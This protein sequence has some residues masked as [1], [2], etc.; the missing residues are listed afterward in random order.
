MVIMRATLI[1]PELQRIRRLH[2]FQVHQGNNRLVESFP[3]F[4]G[5][6]TD[7]GLFRLPHM[8]AGREN[9]QRQATENQ[10]LFHD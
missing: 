4:S 1:L 3:Y 9:N 8:R 7:R 10:L 5:T 6:R 2:I